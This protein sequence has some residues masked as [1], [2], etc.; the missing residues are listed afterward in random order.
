[1]LDHRAERCGAPQRDVGPP[2]R[3]RAFFGSGAS[4][5]SA[6]VEFGLSIP[7]L[8]V[9]LFGIVEFGRLSY[10]RLT[11]RHAVVEATR[12]AVTGNRVSDPDSGD[13]LGRVAS[14]E[15]TLR[16]RS[17][18]ITIDNISIS[19]ADGGGPEDIVTVTVDF[20]YNFLLPGFKNVL[21]PIDFSVSASMRNEP[22]FPTA[23]E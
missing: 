4:R 14:I 13:L 16:N 15:Q 1:M 19:P 9:L 10:A 17:P 11:V 20:T 22:Y 8:L 18:N 21:D 23:D 2:D 3:L 5:G 7:I 6:L 12:F